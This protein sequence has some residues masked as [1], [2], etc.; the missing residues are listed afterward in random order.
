LVF[1]LSG[2]ISPIIGQ[3]YGAKQLSRVKQVLR[4]SLLF[5]AAYVIFISIILFLFQNPIISLFNL[6]GEAAELMQLFCTWIAITFMFNGAQFVSNTAFNNLGKPLYATWFNVG[7]ATVGTLPFVIIGGQY[8]GADGV[9]IGQAAG[10]FIFAVAG[11][12]VA[13][14]LTANLERQALQHAKD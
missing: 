1:A 4:D 8:W 9:L 13:T 11:V 3:N 2:A 7:K 10:G 6:Q 12:A 5:N 14:R